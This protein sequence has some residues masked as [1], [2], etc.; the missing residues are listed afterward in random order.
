MSQDGKMV[1]RLRHDI[2]Q[3]MWRGL[4]FFVYSFLLSMRSM[5]HME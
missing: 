5:G 1:S 2:Q 4:S 3:V